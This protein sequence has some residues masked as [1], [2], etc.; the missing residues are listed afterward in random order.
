MISQFA[1]L[2]LAFRS[3]AELRRALEQNSATFCLGPN[4]ESINFGS[5]YIVI[6]HMFL[7]PVYM[8]VTMGYRENSMFELCLCG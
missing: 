7:Y 5:V 8:G 1:A 3:G 4:G 6:L 2:G